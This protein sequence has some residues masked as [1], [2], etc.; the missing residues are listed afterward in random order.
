[1]QQ[2]MAERNAGVPEARRILY[3]IG[4]NLGDVLIDGE[5]I[6]GD[7]VN[8]AARLEAI[9]EPGG[10]CI[11]GS[12]YDHVRGRIEAEFADLG[13]KAL[14]NIARPV[15]AYA[16]RGRRHRLRKGLDARSCP[17]AEEAVRARAA[18]R[19]ARGA[20]GCGRG[21][22]V[23]APRC[24]PA[25]KRR[26]EGARRGRASF[27]RRAA[28]RQS[29]GRSGAGLPRRRPDRRTDHQSRAHPRHLRHRA[30]HGHDLQGQAGRRQ[31]DRQGSGRALCSRRLGAAERRSDEGQRPAHRRRQRRSSLGRQFDTP[32]ADLLQTQDAIVAHLAHAMDFQ[33]IAGRGRTPQ[34]DAR[35]QSRRRGLGSPMHRGPIEGRSR[36]ARRRMRHTRSA[37][38]RSPSIPT[39]SAP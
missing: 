30:Q 2:Q 25:R 1:M 16:L 35:G 14:K 36:S 38:R 32:R 8:I 33:L 37:N 27:D 17:N 29:V 39:M 23:V 26:Y 7:G 20:A 13:E 34:T 12:A 10:L 6:L 15:R 11:S 18:R 31:G 24:E 3:R 22:R 4:V 21:R 9:C 5:D 28:L 19:R